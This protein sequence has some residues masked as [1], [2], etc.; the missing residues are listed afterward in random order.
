MP[1]ELD[2]LQAWGVGS[3][4]LARLLVGEDPDAVCAA[5]LAR[6][7]LPPG[8]LGRTVLSRARAGAE[9]V[10]AAARA[11]ADGPRQS[12]EVDVVLGDGRQL[13]G[14]VPDVVGD[15][16]RPV[17]YSRPG[18]RAHLRAWAHHL[19]ATAAH[20]ERRLRTAAVGRGRDGAATFT[21]PP[22]GADEA[23]AVLTDLAGLRDEALCEP[24]PLYLDTSHAF[25]VADRA[26]RDGAAAAAKCWETERGDWLK[27]D[28]DPAHV[29]VLGGVRRFDEIA[30]DPRFAVLALRL[31]GPLLD[32]TGTASP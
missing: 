29:L 21:V 10:A 31:W 3:R 20:P 8:Q 13:V 18:P 22:M 12:L 15:V 30:A 11:A 5:E 27:E 24:L 25:A 32:R 2:G 28:R 9:D 16:V 1:V 6:G 19:A 14:A 7:L 23:L 17:S 4:I 26:G